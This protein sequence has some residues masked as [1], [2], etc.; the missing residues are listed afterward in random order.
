MYSTNCITKTL[1]RMEFSKIVG[2]VQGN[3]AVSGDSRLGL[4]GSNNSTVTALVN[5]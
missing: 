4:R 2:L 3:V 5:Y 1:L